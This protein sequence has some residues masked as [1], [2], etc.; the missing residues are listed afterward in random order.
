[1]WYP[2][3]HP[4]DKKRNKPTQQTQEYSFSSLCENSQILN[5]NHAINI[6]FFLLWAFLPNW[7]NSSTSGFDNTFFKATYKGKAWVESQDIIFA[8]LKSLW[9]RILSQLKFI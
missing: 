1:M 2:L 4:F 5:R 9:V 8:E 7:Y 6:V 3:P